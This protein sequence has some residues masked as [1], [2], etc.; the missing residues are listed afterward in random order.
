MAVILKPEEHSLNSNQTFLN[1][2][3]NDS[4]PFDYA[5]Y[6]GFNNCPS[7][8]LPDVSSKSSLT[9]VY[10]LCGILMLLCVAAILVTIIFVDNIKTIENE[11]EKKVKTTLAKML[12]QEFINILM[13]AKTLDFYLLI[14]LAIYA[15]YELTFMW[16]EFNRVILVFKN[17]TKTWLS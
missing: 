8:K 3:L 17:A 15:G 6:C 10:I 12:K 9:S 1:S 2:T 13:L 5:R 16:S 14:P 7:D 4:K 11:N